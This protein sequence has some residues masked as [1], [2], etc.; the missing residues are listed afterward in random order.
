VTSRSW[1]RQ[2]DPAAVCVISSAYHDAVTS[3]FDPFLSHGLVST[4]PR[5]ASLQKHTNFGVRKYASFAKTCLW[6][7]VCHAKDRQA[8][9]L[10][11]EAVV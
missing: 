2:F 7:P 9:L 6:N 5:L 8:G 10:G 11:V 4:S 3:S 1:G